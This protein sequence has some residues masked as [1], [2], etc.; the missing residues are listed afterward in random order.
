MLLPNKE[1]YEKGIR[2]YLHP[3]KDN[4]YY[5]QLEDRAKCELI[6]GIF[7]RRLDTEMNSGIFQTKNLPKNLTLKIVDN[8]VQGL[9]NVKLRQKLIS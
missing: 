7:F 8:R 5:L 2:A 6:E 3:E 1:E 9:K 4:Q